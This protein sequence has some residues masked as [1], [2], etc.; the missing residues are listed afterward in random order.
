MNK[1]TSSTNR[2][3]SVPSTAVPSAIADPTCK[4]IRLD[5]LAWVRSFADSIETDLL[6]L[7]DRFAGFITRNSFCP[8][9]RQR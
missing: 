3:V 8:T 9:G 5:E 4:E 7:E 1:P 6:T 2:P